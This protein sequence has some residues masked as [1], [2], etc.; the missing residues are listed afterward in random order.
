MRHYYLIF[1]IPLFILNGCD[2]DDDFY[3]D[4]DFRQDMRNFVIGIS[5]YARSIDSEFIIIPQNG[6]E[7]IT[8]DGEN[9]GELAISYLS[10]IQGIGRED[11][12]FGYN[13]DNEP[14]P[15]ID[16]EYMCTFLDIAEQNGVEVLVTDYCYTEQLMD[17]A[18]SWNNKR[19]YTSFSADHRNLD[20]IPNYPAEPFL[21]NSHN[22]NNLRDVKNF[23]YLINP[24]S[25]NSKENFIESVSETDYDLIIMDLFFDDD[26]KFTSNDINLL[27]KKNNGSS[28]LVI[29]Y[30]SIGEAEDYRYY[31]NSSWE[32]D[33]PSWLED[34]NPNWNGNYKVK[35]WDEKWQHLIWGNNDSYLKL[36][37]NAGFDGVYLDIIDAF[38][39]FENK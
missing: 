25:F 23:L 13:G 34:E 8:E 10:A 19:N 4:R 35:Y 31:W 21:V 6:H 24:G 17:S 38:E 37:L 11:L 14:T 5:Q 15:L 12:F 7:L 26:T 2:N 36:I 33:S 9:T 20:N 1:L 32:S 3:E 28:R 18:Y 29:A 27:K 30:M 16:N 39:Y 22:I